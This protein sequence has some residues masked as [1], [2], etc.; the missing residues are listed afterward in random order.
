MIIN[1]EFVINLHETLIDKTGGIKGVR[2]Y[3]LL[4][5]LISSVYQ[6]FNGKDL[7]PNE[8]EKICRISYLLNTRH[9][10]Y[11]GNKRIAMHILAL[12]LRYEGYHYKPTNEEVVEIGFKISQNKMNYKDFLVW[13]NNKI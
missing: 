12:I 2:D 4:D 9:P 13:V 6:T 5:S 3:N 7:Y 1:L 8:I 11:D 10:F